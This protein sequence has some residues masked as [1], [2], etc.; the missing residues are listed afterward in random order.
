MLRFFLVLAFALPLAMPASAQR[1]G[2]DRLVG[3]PFATRSPVI[4]Q[5]GIAATSQPLASQ[6]A[7]DV[8]QKGRDGR[9]RRHRRQRRRSG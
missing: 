1:G 4:A 7:I 9:R 5:H 8:L 2:G 6:V 3:Q